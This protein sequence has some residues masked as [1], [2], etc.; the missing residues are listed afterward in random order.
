MPPVD[1][2]PS[3]EDVSWRVRV[4]AE[5][6]DVA[7]AFVRTHRIEIGPALSFDPH[8][9]RATALEHVLAALGADVATGL[10]RLAR[11]HGVELHGVEATARAWSANPLAYLRVVGEDG[12]PG[13][14][15]VRIRVY[16]TT[17][18]AEESVRAL[19]EETLE[20]SPLVSTLRPCVEMELSVKTV[21]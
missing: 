2:V 6:R 20:S 13:L 11:R 1:P 19:W 10:L 21:M 8:E 9:P 15:R 7:T 18:A 5:R 17:Q 12:S 3:S 14:S 16:A 4:A